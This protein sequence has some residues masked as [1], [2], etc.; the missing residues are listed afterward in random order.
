MRV[1]NLQIFQRKINIDS[2]I[3]EESNEVSECLK[4]M[5]TDNFHF[6]QLLCS[7]TKTFSINGHKQC[8]VSVQH[9]PVYY[10]LAWPS[11]LLQCIQSDLPKLQWSFRLLYLYPVLVAEGKKSLINAL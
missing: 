4:F 11:L 9:G 8:T 7:A 6:S 5:K 1:I 3:S 10:L 2:F